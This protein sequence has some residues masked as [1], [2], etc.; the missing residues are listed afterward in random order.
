MMK[1]KGKNDS[2]GCTYDRAKDEVQKD[3][4]AVSSFGKMNSGL[5]K[6]E[7]KVLNSL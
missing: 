4:A 6:K 3:A 5:I 7:M 2:K 1:A